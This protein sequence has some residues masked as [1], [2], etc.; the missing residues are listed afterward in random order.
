MDT[1]LISEEIVRKKLENLKIDKSPGPDLIHPRILKELS[2]V[3]AL[4]LSIIFNSSVHNGIL[5]NIWKCANVTAIYKKR[6]PKV[7]W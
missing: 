2:D 7:C 1:V 3:V 6:R 5:P 4:P